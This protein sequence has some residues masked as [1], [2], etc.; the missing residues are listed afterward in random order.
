MQ[1]ALPQAAGSQPHPTR[2]AALA[3]I[4]ATLF[5]IVAGYGMRRLANVL[6]PL[7]LAIGDLVTKLRLYEATR[8]D[9]DTLFLGTSRVAFSVNPA[10]FDQESR[11]RGCETHSFNLAAPGI[12]YPGYLYLLEF[13]ARDPP[14]RLRRILFEPNVNQMDRR[15]DSLYVRHFL[16]LTRL[17]DYIREAIANPNVDAERWT[18]IGYLILAYAYQNTG[19]SGVSEALVRQPDQR[20]SLVPSGF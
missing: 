2:N 1:D 8:N 17:F 19:I 5:F 12:R 4:A 10:A 9:V 6:D 20:S 3:L 15:W 18:N 16:A 11:A 7:P 13:L 14:P